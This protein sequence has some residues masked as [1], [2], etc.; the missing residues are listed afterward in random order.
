MA[1]FPYGNRWNQFPSMHSMMRHFDDLFDSFVD[2][3]AALR[4]RDNA[5]QLKFSDDGRSFEYRINA[6]GYR[7]EE[8]KVD[9]EENSVVI[10]VG[11]CF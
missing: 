4:L 6:S 1:L 8:L 7:P 3:Q 10:E 11:L 5:G 9:L 2:N